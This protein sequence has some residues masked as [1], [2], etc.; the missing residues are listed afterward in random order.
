MAQRSFGV[1]L[2]RPYKR[3]AGMTKVYATPLRLRVS[4]VP[5]DPELEA[6]VPTLLGRELERY[7]EEVARVA[8]RFADVTGPRGGTGTVCHIEVFVNDRDPIVVEAHAREAAEAFRKAS[9]L[10]RNA[11]ARTPEKKPRPARRPKRAKRAPKARTA[12]R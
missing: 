10:A 12:R 7:A 2:P 6:R 5:V 1:D 4:G 3:E 8:L 9:T 11:L